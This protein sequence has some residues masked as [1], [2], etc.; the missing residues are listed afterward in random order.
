MAPSRA[1]QVPGTAPVPTMSVPTVPIKPVTN[2]TIEE[3]NINTEVNEICA[4]MSVD[5][6]RAVV[7]DRKRIDEIYQSWEGF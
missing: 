5:E 3:P 7:S 6:L 1:A 2:I 4:G